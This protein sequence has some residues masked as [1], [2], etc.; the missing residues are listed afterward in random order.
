M[1]L[2]LE[3]AQSLL[4][5]FSEGY[6]EVVPWL[7]E[8]KTL[9]DQLSLNT[10]SYEAFREQQELLQVLQNLASLVLPLLVVTVGPLFKIFFNVPRVPY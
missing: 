6:A 2:Q 10:I 9:T 8:T 4:S 3:H 5:Q 7:Q 1:V